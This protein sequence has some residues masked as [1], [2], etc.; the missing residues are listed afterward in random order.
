M[1]F[2]HG[3]SETAQA[4]LD[5]VDSRSQHYSGNDNI[6]LVDYLASIGQLEGFAISN[7]MKYISRYGK[8]NGKNK[9]D[10]LKCMH[11]ISYLYYYNY[12]KSQQINKLDTA[13][14]ELVTDIDSFSANNSDAWSEDYAE[15]VEKNKGGFDTDSGYIPINPIEKIVDTPNYALK[16][17]YDAWNVKSNKSETVIQDEYTITDRMANLIGCPKSMLMHPHINLI[18]EGS[19]FRKGE[20]HLANYIKKLEG[21]E[22]DKQK[23]SLTLN[24]VNYYA[25]RMSAYKN[26][27]QKSEQTLEPPYTA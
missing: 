18:Q 14:S 7:V 3:E 26:I 2:K 22:Y 20:N 25:E 13:V 19:T 27:D 17:K 4:F 15:S 1:V 10:L 8:K 24:T 6:E 9:D 21:Q 16:Q 23:D 11:Y 12:T 5:Y